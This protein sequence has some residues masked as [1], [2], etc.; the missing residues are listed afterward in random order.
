M[1]TIS[2]KEAKD[3][4]ADMLNK[5]AYGHKR[6]KIAR[7]N[8]DIAV[9]ISVEEWD[10]IEKLLQKIEDEEDIREAKIAL[11]EIEKKGSIPFDEMKKRLGL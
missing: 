6:F 11:N 2:C 5:V 1:E 8:K 10:K 9:I 7:H 3:N 4:M